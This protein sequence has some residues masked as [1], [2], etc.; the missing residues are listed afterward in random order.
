[1]VHWTEIENLVKAHRL[2]SP[3]A[4]EGSLLRTL[5]L[6]WCIKYNRPFKDPLLQEYNIDELAYEYLTHYFLDPEND[7]K[8]KVVETKAEQ[9][10][11]EWIK[12]QIESMAVKPKAEPEPPKKDEPIPELPPDISTRFDG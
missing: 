10:D 11:Q 4:T 9:E 6:W 8:K 7:P 5:R 2:E 3:T 1:M 12:K